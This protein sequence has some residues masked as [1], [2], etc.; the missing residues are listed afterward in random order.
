MGRR[1]TRALAVALLVVAGSTLSSSGADTSFPARLVD[2]DGAV[3]DVATLAR[4]HKLFFVTLKATSCPV[5]HAQ[6]R[7]LGEQLARL[8]SCDAT[9]VVLSPGPRQD[10]ER[11]RVETGFPF[12]FVEDRDLSLADSIG[13]RLSA[14]EMTP[15]IFA[16]DENR[17]IVWK[18]QGRSGLYFGDPELLEYLDCAALGV[19]RLGE[20]HR[21]IRG[22]RETDS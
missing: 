19:A 17:E 13:L 4:S 21:T 22:L 16:V 12:P 15:A 8:R 6:L 2:V 14:T 7:R 1:L 18:Q 11:I 10:I 9:F 3:V 20:S 5:C